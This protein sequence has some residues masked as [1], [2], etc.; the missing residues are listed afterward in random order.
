MRSWEDRKP[1]RVAYLIDSLGSGGAQRQAVEIAGSLKASG[2]VDPAF[3]VYHENRFFEPRLRS[4]GIAATI[5]PKR[6]RLDPSLPWRLRS[7]LLRE[8]IDVLH[9]FLPASCLYG[10]LATW[11]LPRRHRPL[12]IAAERFDLEGSAAWELMVKRWVYRFSDAITVNANSV[13]TEISS[14]FGIPAARIHYIPNGIDL[15]AWDRLAARPSPWDLASDRFHI[16][17]VGGLRVQ[18]NHGLLLAALSR[19]TLQERAQLNVWFIGDESGEPGYAEHTKREIARLNLG[20]VVRVVPATQAIAA[21]MRRLSALVLPST[22]EGFPNV[23]LESMASGLP[24]VAT[25]V[26]DVPCMLQ[27]GISGYLVGPHDT[28]G[29][30]RVLRRVLGSRPEER[31]EMGRIARK[32]VEARYQLADVAGQYADLYR[33]I[34]QEQR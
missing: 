26:G 25:P 10:R 31:R 4:L 1:I 9:A 7:W 14:R 32:T 18:K 13:A 16:G 22:S 29:L 33:A 17:L 12:F 15:E 3:F 28:D 24:T 2:R 8:S 23:V 6:F 30:A 19:L 5:S 20:G 34:L 21:V 11:T 27:D